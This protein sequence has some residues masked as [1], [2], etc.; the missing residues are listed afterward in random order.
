MYR[1]AVVRV[2]VGRER[3]AVDVL[4][5]HEHDQIQ[6]PDRVSDLNEP[7]VGIERRRVVVFE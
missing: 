4:D 6:R 1:E 7:V 3:D 2:L 5:R